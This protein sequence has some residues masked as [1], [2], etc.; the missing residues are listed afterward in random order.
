MSA[1]LLKDV[2]VASFMVSC[3]SFVGAFLLFH[4]KSVLE[5]MSKYFVSFAAGILLA[6]AFLD[7]FPEALVEANGSDIFT[8]ALFGITLFFFLEK[9]IVWFHHHDSTH[10]IH[11]T[12]FL[13]LVGDSIHNFFDGLTIAAAFVTSQSLGIAST[14][15]IASHEIPHEIA[16]LSILIHGGMD[17]K[18]ALLFN[19]LSAFTAV[20]GA[21]TGLYF[22]NSFK[23]VIPLA[24]S[25][26]AGIFI[27]IAC[28]DL[29]P[30][31]HHNFKKD[32]RWE[33][34]VPF[35][36]GIFLIYILTFFVQG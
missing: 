21:V 32:K 7:I 8:P 11:P 2:L 1:T 16:N 3:I 13:I 10:D 31:L 19:F 17:K 20:I 36:L 9:F 22:F 27:Y 14:I 29:I 33:Q 30:D 18:K 28:S 5:K 15:A 25:F 12:A 23:T 26:S 35:V 4:D 34:S 6:T 24:L